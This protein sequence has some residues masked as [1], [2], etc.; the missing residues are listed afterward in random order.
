MSYYMQG[1]LAM[2]KISIANSDSVGTCNFLLKTPLE[3]SN[4]TYFRKDSELNRL[5]CNI[6]IPNLY[7]PQIMRSEL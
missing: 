2:T 6:S 1:G 4:T 5:L 3:V 7:G